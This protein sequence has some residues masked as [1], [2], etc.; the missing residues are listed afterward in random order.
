MSIDAE[1]FNSHSEAILEKFGPKEIAVRTVISRKYYYVYHYIKD[2][3]NW[4][5]VLK[6]DYLD[7][8]RAQR[9]LD[10]I[11]EEELS[12]SLKDLFQRRKKADYKKHK[13]INIES[14]DEFEDALDDFMQEI[15]KLANQ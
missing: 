9:Y 6:T 4:Q 14:L 2:N 8:K 15:T 10:R 13:H 11:E 5:E 1:D 7:H 3:F 12:Q